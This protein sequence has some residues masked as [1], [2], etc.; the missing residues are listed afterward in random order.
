MR[1]ACPSCG[2]TV[3]EPR[4]AVAHVKLK[5]RYRRMIDLFVAKF[6]EWVSVD[7]LASVFWPDV[8]ESPLAV[9][10]ILSRKIKLLN[11]QL[12][13]VGL[14]IIGKPRRGR[15]LIWADAQNG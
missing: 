2:A 9:S 14:R 13:P 6:G 11:I 12:E 1:H 15:K 10:S 7:E 5:S 3:V 8:E 4:E